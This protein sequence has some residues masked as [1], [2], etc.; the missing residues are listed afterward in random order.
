MNIVFLPRT[1]H[2][3]LVHYTAS[4][5]TRGIN[6]GSTREG[7]AD[8]R[9]GERNQV[10]HSMSRIGGYVLLLA[11]SLWHKGAYNT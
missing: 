7:R 3:T 8:E 4:Q 1:Q 2:C 9:E 5:P 11:G 6:L 10:L